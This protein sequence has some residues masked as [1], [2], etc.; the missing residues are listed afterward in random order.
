[1]LQEKGEDGGAGALVIGVASGGLDELNVLGLSERFVQPLEL[2]MDL[3]DGIDRKD[4][5]LVRGGDQERPG[6]DERADVGQVPE[7]GVDPPHAVAVAVDHA[8]VNV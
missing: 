3:A 2:R 7:G 8:L 6:G 5:V 1:M 4:S